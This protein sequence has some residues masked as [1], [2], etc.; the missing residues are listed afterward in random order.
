MDYRTLGRR[1]C[2]VSALC[3]GTMMFAAE[4]D[5]PGAHEQL[6]HFAAAGG[7]LIDTADVYSHGVSDSRPTA[8]QRRRAVRPPPEPLDETLRTLDG[9]VRAGK[10][11]YYGF[12]I[13]TGWQL[14]KA[15]HVARELNLSPPVTVQPQYS[16]LVREIEWEI[17]P[18]AQDA[19]LG[20]LPWSPLGGGWL[21]RAAR[22]GPGTSST[23]CGGWPGSVACPWSGS[24]WPG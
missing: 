2:A 14:T 13:F 9:F 19:G 6:D 21:S 20:L 5:E 22:S 23:R 17:V 3:L 8:A 4:T 10:I 16:L 24:R 1:G 7:T 11:R 15:G 18:A 12:A